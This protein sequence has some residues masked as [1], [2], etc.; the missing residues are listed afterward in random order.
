[1]LYCTQAC[2]LGLCR[3]GPLDPDCSNTPRARPAELLAAP[4]RPL[5]LRGVSARPRPARPRSR[6]WLLRV[7]GKVWPARRDWGPVQEDGNR[8]TATF[9]WPRA[10]KGRCGLSRR[11]GAR[12]YAR[13]PDLQGTCIPRLPGRRRPRPP[14][15][16]APQPRHRNPHDAPL[17]GRARQRP[18]HQ[19]HLGRPREGGHSHRL[20]PGIPAMPRPREHK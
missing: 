15:L 11:R 6:P 5:G 8:R 13:C 17:V 4:P 2:L 7:P 3:G 1:M 12:V 14:P 16:P 10:S 19:P 20:S 18:G 9:V